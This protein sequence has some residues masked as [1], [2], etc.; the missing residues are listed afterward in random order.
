M[1]S[2]GSPHTALNRA[3]LPIPPLRLIL[4]PDYFVDPVFDV[5]CVLF[6]DVIGAAG[7]L[8]GAAGAGS[9][10]ASFSA[11]G[12]ALAITECITVDLTLWPD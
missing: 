12:F 3:R 10:G 5:S 9:L 8:T 11:A 6:S 7:T 4:Y 2:H 1:N